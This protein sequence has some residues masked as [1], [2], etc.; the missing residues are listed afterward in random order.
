MMIL[1]AQFFSRIHEA[2]ATRGA[3]RLD[4]WH[5]GAQILKHFG[6]FGAGLSNFPMAYTRRTQVMPRHYRGLDWGAH[7]I[8]LQTAVESGAVGLSSVPACDALAGMVG[9]TVSQPSR[10]GEHL[11][12]GL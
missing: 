12:G 9:K 3:G 10:P 6:L 4:I 5:V 11:A 7:N 8:Y 2:S 1:P